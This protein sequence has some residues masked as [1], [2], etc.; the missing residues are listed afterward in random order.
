[1]LERKEKR[2]VEKNSCQFVILACAYTP[3]KMILYS[4]YLSN[5]AN[6]FATWLCAKSIHLHRNLISNCRLVMQWTIK[7]HMLQSTSWSLQSIVVVVGLSKGICS[8][9]GSAFLFLFGEDVQTYQRQHMTSQRMQQ[10]S[11]AFLECWL[12]WMCLHC[13][14]GKR[15]RMHWSLDQNQSILKNHQEHQQQQVA[16][17]S[18]QRHSVVR[19]FQSYGVY[20]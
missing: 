17:K 13:C 10:P 11:T 15:S 16:L 2:K 18:S 9:T 7:I 14:D 19:T 1:M 12:P 4:L 20:E 5:F 8:V 6:S 3:R